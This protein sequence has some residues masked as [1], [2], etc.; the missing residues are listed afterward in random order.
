MAIPTRST[1][2]KQ[3]HNPSSVSKMINEERTHFHP[4]NITNESMLTIF[5]LL[6][7]LD[8]LLADGMTIVT[9]NY[10]AQGEFKQIFKSFLEL[11]NVSRNSPTTFQ[12]MDGNINATQISV[13]RAP[14]FPFNVL[15]TVFPPN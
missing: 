4:V 12:C 5:V 14:K 13:E 10:T 8:L 6:T 7:L 1:S 3:T 9:K 11:R 15:G 2:T